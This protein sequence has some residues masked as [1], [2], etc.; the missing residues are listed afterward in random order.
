MISLLRADF[1]PY[2]AWL[3]IHKFYS[4]MS[5][6]LVR[7]LSRNP[8]QQNSGD[9]ANIYHAD[10]LP[11]KLPKRPVLYN[12]NLP[13][14]QIPDLNVVVGPP[15]DASTSFCSIWYGTICITPLLFID[16]STRFRR[17]NPGNF[18]RDRTRLNVSRQ[19][20]LLSAKII[21]YD[22]NFQYIPAI[23]RYSAFSVTLYVCLN[24]ENRFCIQP[25]F[26][27]FFFMRRRYI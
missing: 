25:I 5:C 21:K 2:Q 22:M 17:L 15:D 26:Y 9:D 1:F 24:I 6:S 16:K 19:T 7:L 8:L 23:F 27:T 3:Y 12:P 14:D 4:H 10:A 11:M 13:W 20:L 18:P